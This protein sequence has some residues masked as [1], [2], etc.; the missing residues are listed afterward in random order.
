[1]SNNVAIK[2]WSGCPMIPIWIRRRRLSGLPW[3]P[4]TLSMSE[5][6]SMCSLASSTPVRSI[7][8]FDG[9]PVQLRVPG[10]RAATKSFAR[11]SQVWIMRVS[12]YHSHKSRTRSKSPFLSTNNLRYLSNWQLG[13]FM[14]LNSLNED[15]CN[16][17][18][19][20][21]RRPLHRHTGLSIR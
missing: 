4:L 16:G 18:N 11:L 17:N 5:R 19:Q 2:L 6:A 21:R 15:E 12:R 3:K 20:L 8:W 14:L 9:G 10:T 7:S 13:F 1:M